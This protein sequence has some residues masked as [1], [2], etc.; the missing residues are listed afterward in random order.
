MRLIGIDFSI[1]GVTSAAT[2]AAGMVQQPAHI[3]CDARAIPLADHSVDA[4]ISIEVLQRISERELVLR[5]GPTVTAQEGPV[6]GIAVGGWGKQ[7][8]LEMEPLSK[9]VDVLNDHF[10]M[11]LGESNSLDN[12]RLV[13]MPKFIKMY[14]RCTVQGAGPTLSKNRFAAALVGRFRTATPVRSH[15]NWC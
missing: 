4:V 2:R 11:K 14:I 5:E 9:I 1:V 6:Q 10:G 7:H 13:F 12:F 3:A 15:A 8:E